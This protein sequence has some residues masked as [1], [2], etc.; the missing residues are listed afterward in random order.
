MQRKMAC[1]KTLLNY[2]LIFCTE[3][4]LISVGGEMLTKKQKVLLFFNWRLFWQKTVRMDA[5]LIFLLH[6]A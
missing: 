5:N 6:F 2:I 1:S 4:L 3:K